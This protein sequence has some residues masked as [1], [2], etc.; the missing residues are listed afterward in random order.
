M[1]VAYLALL[2][3]LSVPITIPLAAPAIAQ[4]AADCEA[5]LAS[6]RSASGGVAISGKNEDKDRASLVRTLEAAS[7]ELAKGKYADAA[8]KLGD[9]KVKV[10][11]LLAA[12]RISSADASSLTAQADGAIACLNGLNG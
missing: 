10:Q 12:S 2:A 4:S 3:S 9:F 7:T 1:R 6:L 11:Q 8:T 5:M